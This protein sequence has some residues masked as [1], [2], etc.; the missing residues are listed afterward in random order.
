L[1]NITIRKVS[2]A[3]LDVLLNISK[4][5]FFDAFEAL[6]NPDDFKA[7]TSV[8]FTEDKFRSELNN[9]NSE[10][11]FAVDQDNIV[12]YLKLNFAT[13]QTEFQD[14][15]ALEI[16]RIYVSSAYQGKQIG[17]LLLEHAVNKA[18]SAKL[19]YVW[20]GVFEKNTHAIRFYE[21]NGFKKFSS[22]YFMIG[23]DRQTDFLMK[24]ML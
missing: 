19:K 20:L 22:H 13:A 24:R 6:N 12:G 16:E 18:R 17:Q 10:F 4:Q 23:N 3:D 21:R 8:A 2:L 1:H 15:E 11:Y 5:T 7:Y 14:T 9:P